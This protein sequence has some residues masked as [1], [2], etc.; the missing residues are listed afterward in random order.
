MTL[1]SASALS[2]FAL[3]LLGAGPAG[4]YSEF[5]GEVFFG[6][7]KGACL[8]PFPPYCSILE[9]TAAEGDFFLALVD[10]RKEDFSGFES[11]D[12]GE[13][14]LWGGFGT[15]SDP[16]EEQYGYIGT[17]PHE[18]RGF[19]ITGTP[20]WKNRAYPDEG[21]FAVDFEDPVH[22][23]GFYATAYSTT[24]SEGEGADTEL[25]LRLLLADGGTVSVPIDHWMT[26]QA[27]NVFY[28]GVL[29]D[30]PFVRATLVNESDVYGDV[31]G[32]DDFTVAIVPEPA[33]GG[34]LAGG[35]F[36]LA[37]ARR[38]RPRG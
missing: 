28:F 19:P 5:H 30:D 22:A 38:S 37:A 6:E 9:S 1:R 18:D 13:L 24:Q 27:G 17:G 34:L 3:L 35:L 15:L 14:E 26:E 23:F 7:D 32:F 25:V 8:D 29:S 12:D 36:A 33:T 10:P 20:F 21:L 2:L 4:A 11:G 31:I 16:S